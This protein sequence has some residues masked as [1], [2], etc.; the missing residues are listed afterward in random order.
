MRWDYKYHE[1]TEMER[2]M[3]IYY[4]YTL[5]FLPMLQLNFWLYLYLVIGLTI[6]SFVIAVKVSSSSLTNA[7]KF[8]IVSVITFVALILFGFVGW[9][10]FMA[11]TV[12]S[13][14]LM[15]EFRK[16]Y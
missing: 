2:I 9:L 15:T 6:L 16:D 7:Q 5:G 1:D 12:I 4:T 13:Y 14:A 11:V 8:Y 10:L 3:D